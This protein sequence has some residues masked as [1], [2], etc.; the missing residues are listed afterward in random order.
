MLGMT[1]EIIA[2]VSA[3]IGVFATSIPFVI[4]F[5]RKARQ[6]I[7]ERNWNR[8]TELL[9]MLI[10]EAEKFVNYNGS[11]KKEYVKSRL[12]VYS[13]KNNIGFD[14]MKFDSM[15]DGL[16]KLTKEVNKREKDKVSSITQ[17]ALPLISNT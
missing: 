2:V 15:I 5:I 17:N 12:A 10:T 6:L 13:V 8:I 3:A 9:P 14:E 4:S 1:K 16:V 11:E 7:M